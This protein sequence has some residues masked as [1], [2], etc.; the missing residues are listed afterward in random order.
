VR[1]PY[2]KRANSAHAWST[3]GT[4]IALAGLI[5]A[6]RALDPHAAKSWGWPTNWMIIPVTVFGVGLILLFLPVRRSCRKAARQRWIR[7]FDRDYRAFVLAGLRFIDQ[8]GL[9]TVGPFTPEL[10]DVYVDVSLAARPP[11]LVNEGLLPDLPADVT[12]R[13]ALS[14]FLSRPDPVVLAVIGAPGSGK[15]TLLRHTAQQVCQ[16]RGQKRHLPVLL[17]LRDHVGAIVADP[18]VGLTALLRSTLGELRP[19]EPE[20]WFE[21]RLRDGECVVLLDGLDEVARPEDRRKVASWAEDQIRQYPVN[22]YVITSR[23]Q[24]YRAATID[25]AD[26]LQVRGFTSEQVSRFVHGWYLAVERHS[27]S[28]AGE[29]IT[30]R[31]RGEADDL[32]QRLDRAPAL[33]DLTVNPLLL[34]M[35]ANVHRYRG[36]LPGSR[37]DLYA[38]ILQV[39]LV[40][41]QE[42]KNLPVELAGDKKEALLRGL[43]YAMMDRRLSDL[44]HD[45]VLA[46]IRPRLRRL[47]RQVT[48][49]GFLADVGSNG[50]LVERE[51]GLYSFAHHT[52]Q[53]YLA[54]AYIRDKGLS[55]VLANAVDDPWW[56]ETSL[57]YAARA[58]ADSIV[59][60]CLKSGTI[61][62]LALA[63]D[64]AD[65]GSA[66]AEELRQRLEDLLA[67]VSDPATGQ[68]RRRLITGVL[69]ARHLR[70]QFRTRDGSRIC[71]RAITASLYEFF[72]DDTHTPPPDCQPSATT[73]TELASGMRA[74][75]AATFVSWV[76]AVIGGEA[77]YRLPS[78]AAL[79]DPEARRLIVPPST[80]QSRSIWIDLGHSSPE[81]WVSSGMPHPHQIDAGKLAAHLNIDMI[82]AIRTLTVLLLMR[83]AVAANTISSYSILLFP[84]ASDYGLSPFCQRVIA[85]VA[86]GNML[87]RDL[88]RTHESIPDLTPHGGI[89]PA[90]VF[91]R[92]LELAIALDR[93]LANLSATPAQLVASTLASELEQAFNR[94]RD[95]DPLALAL[96]LDRDCDCD[97]NWVLG[98]DINRALDIIV[99]RALDLNLNKLDRGLGSDLTR[100]VASGCS[101]VMGTALSQALTEALLV[102]GHATT[103]LADFAKAFAHLAGISGRKY[104]VSP[105]ELALRI[106]NAIQAFQET[107]TPYKGA[108]RS[109]WATTVGDRLQATAIP[110]FNRQKQLTLADA[111]SIRLAVLCLAAEADEIHQSRIAED[112]REI[113]AGVTFIERRVNGQDPATETIILAS[114]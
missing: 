92:A 4:G 64:C 97:A 114:E 44:P 111:T 11:H 61:A 86:Q 83:S 107:Q 89:D 23:P 6:A 52:F 7:R 17:Y 60:A 113:A 35:I 36:A 88:G 100:A 32:L 69:L 47:P 51:S 95:L 2:D 66:F 38:E 49:E 75:D 93:I 39:M 30:I 70:Q 96:D 27:T 108:T 76:N 103:V 12:E 98:L 16:R 45:Q 110:I 54:A 28:A 74:A 56:R 59:A 58:D 85:A 41:R 94:T 106:T 105:D 13:R 18:C 20:G 34:T 73:G 40:R 37:A 25:G 90:V 77:T 57:L 31:A 10:D 91:N 71:T 99:N 84:R 102:P 33:F 21:Q 9:A 14:E 53:E 104:L 80:T 3:I 62:A 19:A 79:D 24:G 87:I 22:D 55:D 48:A 101:R 68:E 1:W 109:S 65:Q 67:E 43:A 26:V 8:K 72:R 50:L 46:E 81:L 15:T 5:Y 29:D 78:R 82:R 63:F 112:L 42:A